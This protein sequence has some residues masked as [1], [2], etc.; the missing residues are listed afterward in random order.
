MVRIL[1]P[2][3]LYQPR[4][5]EYSPVPDIDTKSQKGISFCHIFIFFT[6]ESSFESLVQQGDEE[7]K[8]G[9][10]NY[11]YRKHVSPHSFETLLP[12][13]PIIAIYFTD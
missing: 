10:Y 3:N 4:K 5:W 11:S 12:S 13:F 2:F 1:L 8:V 6:G 7:R 9:G